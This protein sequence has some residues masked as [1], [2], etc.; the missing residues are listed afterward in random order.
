MDQGQNAGNSS[1]GVTK[2][3]DGEDQWTW[4][5]YQKCRLKLPTA[6]EMTV[7]DCK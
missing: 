6:K 1:W 2:I 3:I 5:P 4:E 7:M